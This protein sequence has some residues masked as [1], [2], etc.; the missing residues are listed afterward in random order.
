MSS[1]KL[2]HYNSPMVKTGHW[3]YQITLTS[4][5]HLGKIGLYNYLSLP[6]QG[7]VLESFQLSLCITHKGIYIYFFLLK[8][9]TQLCFAANCIDSTLIIHYKVMSVCL[10]LRNTWSWRKSTNKNWWKRN[11]IWI[12]KNYRPWTKSE[13]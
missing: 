10:A 13:R 4:Q 6:W 7:I 11:C 9:I 8:M 5:Y 2:C 12:R 3:I 1:Q